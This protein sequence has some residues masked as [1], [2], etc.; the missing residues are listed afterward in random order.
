MNG[1]QKIVGAASLVCALLMT[2]RV[3][4]QQP[5]TTAKADPPFA[6]PRPSPAPPAGRNY[7]GSQTC[8]RC[9]ATM[10]DRWTKTRMANVVLEP[11]AHPD[12]VLGD[13]SKTDP[14]L[15]FKLDDVA[16]VYGSKWK[17]RYFQKQGDD[18]YPLGAQWDVRNNHTVN[19]NAR[20]KTPTE[21]N[22]GCERCHG[23]GSEHVRQPNAATIVNPA[24]LDFVRAND[25]CIQCHPQGQPLTNPILASTT[26]GR[27][28]SIRAGTFA[29]T[30]I[31]KSTRSARRHSRTSRTARRIRIGCRV[32][33]SCRA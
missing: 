31:S 8:R 33:T 9:H 4:T 2:A 28:A 18:Y 14:A 26:T 12:A 3:A 11:K 13:F 20:T 1:T 24:K 29:T 5:A 15:T 25:T 19:Y 32:T 27:S 21:L 7:V 17:Q 30:G 22:V 10:Y 16:L 23:P 6:A